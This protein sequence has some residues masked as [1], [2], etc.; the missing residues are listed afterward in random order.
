MIAKAN[1][2][3]FGKKVISIKD[4]YDNILN[5]KNRSGSQ[6][7]N[8]PKI[9]I[10]DPLKGLLGLIVETGSI[11][12]DLVRELNEDELKMFLKVMEKTELKY[13][14]KFDINK[15]KHTKKYLQNRFKVLQGEILSGNN[16]IEVMH[17][18]KETINELHMI[19]S[20]SQQD[21]KDLLL[22]LEEYNTI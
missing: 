4:L 14:L 12:Y 1:W 7:P 20:I 8:L 18:L 19:G 17:D 13:A 5:L 22:E 15:T 2:S 21:K 9:K 11:D 10:S 16:N 6:V 3:I